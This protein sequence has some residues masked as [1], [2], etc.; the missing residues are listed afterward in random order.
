MP[1]SPTDVR[2]IAAFGRRVAKA[3]MVEVIV[4]EAFKTL[5]AIANIE[6]LRIVYSPSPSF[7]NEWNAST[8]SVEV[9]RNDERPAP[10]KGHFTVLFDPDNS[11]SGFVSVKTR[12]RKA[13]AAMEIL[14]PE[15]W[16]ILLLQ[17]AL[18]R[19][20]RTSVS[21][22][23]LVRETLRARDEERRRIA[24]ELHDDLGQSMASLKLLLKW[25]EGV[26][27]SD[28]KFKKVVTELS[29]ARGN[30]G[31]MMA[32]IRDL[33][34]TLYPRIL[35]T[36]GLSAAVKE[37]AHQV[38]GYSELEVLCTVRGKERKVS[39]DIAVCIYRCCQ[40][41]INNVIRHAD[42]S[43]LVIEIQ[44]ASKELRLTVEDDG[45]GFDPRQLYGPGTRLMSSGFWTIRQRLADLGGAFRVSTAHRKGTV[46]EIIVPY[47]LRKVHAKRKNKTA[48]RR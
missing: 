40:E 46:V 33:S 10:V 22:T 38:A 11:Q 16:S 47:S 12:G 19:I 23:V 15:I 8:N 14:A 36:L 32:R 25:S 20:Q 39:N 9:R 13:A 30:V 24:R 44:F 41:A 3:P 35:D 2:R 1:L 31:D 26:I 7:W 29:R 6:E 45:R 28:P 48:H 18:E 37:L 5:K 17:S 27:G 42:A 43:Q 4:S 21:E 34:H